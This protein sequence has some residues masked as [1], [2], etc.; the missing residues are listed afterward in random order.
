[1]IVNIKP[2]APMLK[3]AM[4]NRAI[5]RQQFVSGQLELGAKEQ[6]LLSIEQF[7]GSRIPA[8]LWQTLLRSRT[9]LKAKV[10]EL[11][12]SL[13]SIAVELASIQRKIEL[14]QEHLSKAEQLE[15]A[16][17]ESREFLQVRQLALLRPER[18]MP[19]QSTSKIASTAVPQKLHRPD[20]PQEKVDSHIHVSLL[21][22]RVEIEV[23]NKQPVVSAV[24]TA[25]D[26]MDRMRLKNRW[27]KYQGALDSKCSSRV[28]L[29]VIGDD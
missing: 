24:L 8:V 17:H 18:N 15:D 2:I 3:S 13:Q 25:R 23:S 4:T 28:N 10:Q 11:R 7:D 14:Y 29:E 5:L 1:M 27:F 9:S 20:L 6:A 26:R 19:E 21:Q 22:G 12:Q 16:I